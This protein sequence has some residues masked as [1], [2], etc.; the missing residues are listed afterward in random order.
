MV[1]GMLD[2]HLDRPLAVLEGIGDQFGDDQSQRRHSFWG[3][4]EIVSLQHNFPVG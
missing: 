3:Q 2:D 1:A 4:D